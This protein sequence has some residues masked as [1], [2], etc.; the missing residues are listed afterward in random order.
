MSFEEALNK[1]ID[2][3]GYDILKDTF[4][5]YSLISDYVG[6]S[7]YDTRLAKLF[8]C[9]YYCF[10]LYELFSTKGLKD[11]RKFL[12]TKYENFSEYTKR[13]FVD[14][15]NPI[16]KRI[17]PDEYVESAKKT[18]SNNLVVKNVVKQPSNKKTNPIVVP[19]VV[20][21]NNLNK[22][23]PKKKKRTSNK[24]SSIKIDGSVK[25][26]KLFYTSDSTKITLNGSTIIPNNSPYANI[27]NGYLE[28][29]NVAGNELKININHSISL[30]NVSINAPSSIV[31][32]ESYVGKSSKTLVVKAKEISNYDFS[33]DYISFYTTS[34]DVYNFATCQDIKINTQSITFI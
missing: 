22:I 30:K 14:A 4:R 12:E 20:P 11:A 19:N 32:L 6:S 31:H 16:A 27:K 8:E 5:T 7:F 13:E 25:K 24:F 1:V 26:I 9:V 21:N 23:P 18:K 33:S 29:L 17:C 2:E 3:Y 15:I 10:D 28:I 34:G